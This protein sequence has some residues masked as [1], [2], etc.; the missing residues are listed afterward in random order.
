MPELSA[1]VIH[2]RIAGPIVLPLESVT[3]HWNHVPLSVLERVPVVN[4]AL[5]APLTLENVPG[6][7]EYRAVIGA[8][9]H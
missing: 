7:F 1:E 8:D 5:V 9:F 3:T 2:T 4:D 6:T